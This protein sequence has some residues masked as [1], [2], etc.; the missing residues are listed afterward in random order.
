MAVIKGI[1]EKVHLPLYDSLFVRPRQ[2][3]REV[4]SSSVL[5][6]FVNVQNK[7][8]LESNMQSASLLPHWNTFEAR[9]LRVVVSDV[10]ALF[11]PEI[12]R[13]LE[14]LVH[15]GESRSSQL[16]ACLEE[17]D[18][19]IGEE[20]KAPG[21]QLLQRARDS[22][23]DT[24]KLIDLSSGIG[25]LENGLDALGPISDQQTAGSIFQ[26]HSE[27]RGVRDDLVKLVERTTI[28]ME[29]REAMKRFAEK[30]SKLEDIG[31]ENDL[32]KGLKEAS[33][34]LEA[35][36]RIHPL[37]EEIAAQD[38]DDIFEGLEALSR[39]VEKNSR[40][41]G[42]LERL[43][44]CLAESGRHKAVR[45]RL[46]DVEQCLKERISDARCRPIRQQ[47]SRGGGEILSQLVYNSVTIFSVGEKVMIQMP[48]WFFPSGAGPYVED[49]DVAT[50]GFP[51]PEATFRF[52]EPVLIDTQQNFR[53]EIEI[54][55]ASVLEDLQRLYGPFFIW[56]V[57]D[58]YMVRD[59]Q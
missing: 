11:P 18:Q 43:R 25:T 21:G 38:L 52:A 20:K 58:G 44:Q 47:L 36:G 37:L 57:L 2:Q 51:S 31:P 29:D 16:E 8:K 33:K 7:T 32:L 49:G 34:H 4:E 42:R 48:T 22:A 45:P 28:Q 24:K 35:L 39:G 26:L 54:P 40:R 56:V 55:E 14:E 27:L 53:V 13:C 15:K 41:I 50:H 5:R 3:L 10:P 46:E 59:V 17:L 12:Q 9:A 30:V 19:L 1:K 6:F 23:I